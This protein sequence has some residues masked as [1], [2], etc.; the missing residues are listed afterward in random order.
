MNLS[1]TKEQDNELFYDILNRNYFQYFK[2][3][4]KSLEIFLNGLCQA[5]CEYCYL[6]KHQKDLFPVKLFNL[7]TIINNFQLIINWY[8]ENHFTNE[9]DIFSGEW[10]TTQLRT[11][12]LTILYNSFKDISPIYRPKRIIFPD[13][14][15]FIKDDNITNEVQEFINKFKQINIPLLISASIDGK[16]CEFGRTEINDEYYK[17]L[18]NFLEINNFGCHPM[19]SSNNIKYWIDNY[20][21]FQ[22]ISPKVAASLM[23]LEVRDETWHKE[24]ITDLLKFCDFLIDYKLKNYFNN[25]LKEFAKY[26]FTP[27]DKYGHNYTPEKIYYQNI[28]KGLDRI[29]CSVQHS[30]VIRAADLKIIICHRTA[31]PELELGE[32]IISNNK[33]SSFN[34]KNIALLIMKLYA[35][36]SCLPHC[37]NC[38]INGICIGHCLGNSYEVCSNPLIPVKEVCDM[39]KA[40]NSF[41]I[42]KYDKLGLFEIIKNENII[43]DINYKNYILDLKD[44]I[45]N[46][47]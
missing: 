23:M 3:G 16:I 9:I 20:L 41:L 31:Y 1:I 6:K 13:N 18:F 46:N 11:P 12:I 35:K 45:L 37:E 29:T 42:Q 38:L 33:I 32:M 2:Q 44:N 15:L 26:I 25:D 34:S 22:K 39:Y 47:L 17:K 7:D 43:L 36:K 21:W 27:T 5:N 30:F 14:M 24:A 4:E 28:D 40:K 10:L 19:I 8:I